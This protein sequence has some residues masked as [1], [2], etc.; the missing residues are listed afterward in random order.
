MADPVAFPARGV[1]PYLHW[2]Y[3]LD[4]D[5]RSTRSGADTLAKLL[6]RAFGVDDKD[7]LLSTKAD[8]HFS[9]SGT[10]SAA[11]AFDLELTQQTLAPAPNVDVVLGV[12]D[13]D[14]PLGHRAFRHADGTSRVLYHWS[15]NAPDASSYGREFTQKDI[16]DLLAAHSPDGDLMQPLDQDGFNTAIGALDYGNLAGHRALGMR[17]SHGAHMLDAAGGCDPAKAPDFAKKVGLITVN[18]PSRW[19]F[20]E[21]GEFLEQHMIQAILRVHQIVEDLRKQAHAG[22]A[23]IPA[24]TSLA[25]GRQAGAKRPDTDLLSRFLAELELGRSASAPPFDLVIPTGND[26]QAQVVA[27]HVIAPQSTLTVDWRIRPADQTDNYLEVWADPDGGGPAQDRALAVGLATPDGT[28]AVSPQMIEPGHYIDASTDTSGGAAKFASRIYRFEK[29]PQRKFQLSGYLIALGPVAPRGD[30][31]GAVP[32]G[33]WTLSLSNRSDKPLVVHLSV[34]TD[35]SVHPVGQL[36][37]RSSLDDPTYRTF[38]DTGVRLDAVKWDAPCWVNTEPRT[39]TRRHGTMNVAASQSV[40][41][42]VSGYRG[43]DGIPAPY[44]SSGMGDDGTPARAGPTAALVTDDTGVLGGT[45]A[46]GSADGSRVAMRGTSFAAAQACRLVVD[47]WL[48][49][50]SSRTTSAK[51][52]LQKAAQSHESTGPFDAAFDPDDPCHQPAKAKLG[53]GRVPHDPRKSQHRKGD[54]II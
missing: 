22:A 33:V 17:H 10:Q 40:T 23:D 38:D 2:Y 52:I 30:S 44:A 47:T 43:S 5:G 3:R 24:V 46:A 1:M 36:S 37:G 11:L 54:R 32:S 15:M 26:N 6:P 8:P 12:I 27:R 42:V 39:G 51:D 4:K 50:K 18:M 13:T 14:I 31:I 21:G 45:L 19:D 35:Q 29:P 9:Y 48:A 41:A 16:N 7:I 34:Q 25:F 49:S 53:H 28:F 20:G